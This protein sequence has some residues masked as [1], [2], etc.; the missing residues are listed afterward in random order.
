[1]DIICKVKDG[2]PVPAKNSLMLVF[3]W[4]ADIRRMVEGFTLSSIERLFPTRDQKGLIFRQFK[5]GKKIK[6]NRATKRGA[7]YIQCFSHSLSILYP[8]FKERI[9]FGYGKFHKIIT[10]V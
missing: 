3:V 5:N 2:I 9:Y 10:Y 8:I 1:M 7:K 4:L 6:N